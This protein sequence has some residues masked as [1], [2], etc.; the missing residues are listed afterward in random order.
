MKLGPDDVY[1][2]MTWVKS[3]AT[4]YDRSFTANDD[5]DVYDG[6]DVTSTVTRLTSTIGWAEGETVAR[7]SAETARNG[8][9]LTKCGIW[10]LT[11]LK[12]DS[13][14]GIFEISGVGLNFKISGVGITRRLVVSAS[15]RLDDVL[16]EL[17]GASGSAQ[18]DGRTG[19][20]SVDEDQGQSARKDVICIWVVNGQ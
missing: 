18:T 19:N 20:A 2:L 14:V 6:A 10:L 9:V 12:D 7:Q 3:D 17:S 1:S 16:L 4:E 8:T 13:G 5:A 11:V 15:L